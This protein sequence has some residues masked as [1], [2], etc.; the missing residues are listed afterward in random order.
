MAGVRDTK[1]L[2]ESEAETALEAIYREHFD[3]VWSV[4]R[5]FGVDEADVDDAC[6]DVFVIAHRRLGQFEGRAAIRTWLYSIAMRVA[7]NRRRKAARRHALLAR[8]P[9]T[10][11]DDLEELA[12]RGQARAILERLLDRLDEHKRVVFV[13]AELEELTVPAIASLV[14][15]NPRTI[16]SRL[17]AARAA[18]AS[19]LDR[20]HA[21]EPIEIGTAIVATRPR[22]S[23]PPER[24]RRAWAAVLAKVAT[25]GSLAPLATAGTALR[26]PWALG[27]LAIAV[28]GAIGVGTWSLLPERDEP[29]TVATGATPPLEREASPERSAG[30]PAVIDA[31]P[32][33]APV[34]DA[35]PQP[36][37]THTGTVALDR[38]PPPRAEVPAAPAPTRTLAEEVASLDRARDRLRAGDDAGALAALDEHARRFSD[39]ELHREAAGVR[40]AALCHADRTQD[41]ES[42]AQAAGL[43]RPHCAAR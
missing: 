30:T 25:D 27:K 20:L 11:P 39:G 14:G 31:A 34:S 15:E 1:G 18:V 26:A 12:A 21:P 33:T 42:V 29:P 17:R 16:Y 36:E 4:L 6:Q 35:A 3:L 19:A 10:V 38:T 9:G 5:R 7:A 43:P 23:V 37:K 2:V 40:V 28:V 8:M 41:A 22:R 24:A 13:L 32:I